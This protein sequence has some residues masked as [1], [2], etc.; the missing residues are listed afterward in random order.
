[1]MRD[2]DRNSEHVDVWLGHQLLVVR[3]HPADPERFACGT[4]GFRAVRAQCAD[5]VVRQRTQGRDVGG[6]GPTP[7]GADTDDPDAQL[8]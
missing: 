5:F 2:L 1:M 3:E 7:G 4:R 6:G 8:R